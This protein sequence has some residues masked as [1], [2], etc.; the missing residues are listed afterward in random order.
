MDLKDKQATIKLKCASCNLPI[1]SDDAVGEPSCGCNRAETQSAEQRNV[2]GA[3]EIVTE[4]TP[5]EVTSSEQKSDKEFGNNYKVLGILGTGG[6]GTVYRVRDEALQ[7]DFAIKKLRPELISDEVNLKRFTNE[8]EAAGQFTHPNLVGVYKHGMS[9]DGS[10]YFLMD[11]IEG[12]SL[13]ELLKEQRKLSVHQALDIFMQVCEA[14]AH[15]HMKGVVHRDLKPSNILITKT[16]DGLDV[17]KI[18]DFGVSKLFPNAEFRETQNLTR[19]GDVLGTPLYM[20][21][22]QC[23]GLK[24]DDRSDIYSLGCVMYEALTGRPPFVGENP[25]QIIAQHLNDSASEFTIP[26]DPK[27]IKSFEDVILKAISKAPEDRYQSMDELRID[28]EKVKDG[29]ATP[30]FKKKKRVDKL[31]TLRNQMTGVIAIMCF[32]LSFLSTLSTSKYNEQPLVQVHA[33]QIVYPL[34]Q[35]HER[36]RSFAL[37][38]SSESAREYLDR[39]NEASYDLDGLYRKL[40]KYPSLKTPDVDAFCKYAN[41]EIR[42]SKDKWT[43]ILNT[44]TNAAGKTDL[45]IKL[46]NNESQLNAMAEK[47]TKDDHLKYAAIRQAPKEDDYTWVYSVVFFLICCGLVLQIGFRMGE[48]SFEERYKRRRELDRFGAKHNH[49]WWRGE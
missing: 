45:D 34:N 5:D 47:I 16:T 3:H 2:P 37:N 43:E 10:P 26:Q 7:K 15:A 41:E 24:T 33:K 14:L 25:V 35:A 44:P 40:K 18:V 19:T 38:K 30:S 13:A 29:Q 46:E 23:M 4:A 6:M 11:C 49:I 12:K 27:L 28:L 20:S 42:L 21:P 1:E 17:V 48:A 9:K 39:T 36:L 8:I 22:E 32:G 31:S